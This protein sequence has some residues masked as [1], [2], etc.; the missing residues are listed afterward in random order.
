MEIAEVEMIDIDVILRFC[1][2]II[3]AMVF[4]IKIIATSGFL[5]FDFAG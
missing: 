3:D 2:V 1:Y 5:F 4:I